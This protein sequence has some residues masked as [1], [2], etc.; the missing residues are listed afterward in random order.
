MVFQR[1][2]HVRGFRQVLRGA[3]RLLARAGDDDGAN[4]LVAL[5][6]GQRVGQLALERAIERVQ[7]SRPIQRELPDDASVHARTS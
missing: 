1:A 3:E 6:P 2:A 7:H 4:A 5:D